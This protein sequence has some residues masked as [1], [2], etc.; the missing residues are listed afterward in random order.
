[1]E[2]TTLFSSVY[3]IAKD[4][5]IEQTVVQR[6]LNA[7]FDYCKQE[8]CMGYRVSFSDIAIIVPKYEIVTYK[9]TL[10]YICYS[11]AKNNGFSFN[12]VFTV[13][14]TFLARLRDDII[15]GKP[16]TIRGIVT[17][18][19]YKEDGVITRV[20]SAISQSLQNIVKANDNSVRA[21]T[22]QSIKRIIK[23]VGSSDR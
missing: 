2:K 12:T 3:N 10:G 21:H 7:Y 13:V 14:D 17:L 23:G 18:K 15:E 8:L 22:H 5:H 19:P 16:A 4:L 20:H 9:A 1:M 11:I 6:I